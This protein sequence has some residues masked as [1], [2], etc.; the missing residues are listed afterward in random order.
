MST[1]RL[2]GKNN[3]TNKKYLIYTA[4]RSHNNRKKN[5]INV[6]PKLNE[7][8]MAANIYIISLMSKSFV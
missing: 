6:R 7:K 5:N 8:L 4:K 1:R 2:C 3:I